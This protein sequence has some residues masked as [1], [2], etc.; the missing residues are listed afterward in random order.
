MYGRGE[1]ESTTRIEAPSFAWTM[2]TNAADMVRP[3]RNG[4]RLARYMVPA[5]PAHGAVRL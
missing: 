4:N 5:L 3:A 1:R 2:V